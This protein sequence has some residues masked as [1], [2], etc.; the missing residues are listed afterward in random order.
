MSRK[1]KLSHRK[2]WQA[3]TLNPKTVCLILVRR[4]D[5]GLGAECFVAFGIHRSKG[6]GFGCFLG[7]SCGP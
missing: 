4:D 3:K 6:L 2:Y 7:Q 1:Y 5:D